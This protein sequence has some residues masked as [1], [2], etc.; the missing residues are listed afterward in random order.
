MSPVTGCDSIMQRWII[1]I[2]VSWV[3]LFASGSVLIAASQPE[4][5][6]SE[7]AIVVSLPVFV[8][9]LFATM[10]GSWTVARYMCAREK[11]VDQLQEQINQLVKERDG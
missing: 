2:C 4:H 1:L 10:C 3:M 6:V 11:R 8:I 5:T 7:E 9:S